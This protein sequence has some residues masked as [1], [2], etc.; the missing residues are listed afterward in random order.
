MT[1]SQLYLGSE[2]PGKKWFK[3]VVYR[4]QPNPLSDLRFVFVVFR[5]QDL[6]KDDF[7]MSGSSLACSGTLAIMDDGSGDKRI[8]YGRDGGVAW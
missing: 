8:A 5:D 2:F 4:D 7:S 1:L 3:S 6:T